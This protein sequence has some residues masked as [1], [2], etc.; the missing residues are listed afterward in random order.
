MK[1]KQD[2]EHAGGSFGMARNLDDTR[3]RNEL[4]RER[5][6]RIQPVDDPDDRR[7]QRQWTCK[8]CHLPIADCECGGGA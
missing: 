4:R 5:D 3:L 7:H 1:A 6:G 8:H 2:N